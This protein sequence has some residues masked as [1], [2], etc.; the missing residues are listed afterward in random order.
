MTMNRGASNSRVYQMCASSPV[1]AEPPP[2]W[3]ASAGWP[4]CQGSEVSSSTNE[5]QVARPND[6]KR[7]DERATTQYLVAWLL[8]AFGR[9]TWPPSLERRCFQ[10]LNLFL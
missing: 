6:V 2:S 1:E 7:C 8:S 4:R 9:A 3:E 5:A 10:C